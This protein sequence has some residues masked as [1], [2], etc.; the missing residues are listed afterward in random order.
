MYKTLSRRRLTGLDFPLFGSLDDRLD[1]RTTRFKDRMIY[2]KLEGGRGLVK[3]VT[4][5]GGGYAVYV[6]MSHNNI[7]H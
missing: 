4:I 3:K 7:F 2:I 5:G 6:R 1:Y